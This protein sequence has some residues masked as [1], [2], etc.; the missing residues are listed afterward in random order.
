MK[1][2]RIAGELVVFIETFVLI[3]FNVHRF[4]VAIGQHI[5][6]DLSVSKAAPRLAIFCGLKSLY[7]E[8]TYE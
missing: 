7:R 6:Q 3:I 8:S 5:G 2:I 4:I 1:D